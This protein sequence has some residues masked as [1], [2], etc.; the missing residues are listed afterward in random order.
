MSRK[1]PGVR[2]WYAGKTPPDDSVIARVEEADDDAAVL[3]DHSVETNEG[4]FADVV[5]GLYQKMDTLK[6]NP[7]DFRTWTDEDGFET[8]LSCSVRFWSYRAA[9]AGLDPPENGCLQVSHRRYSR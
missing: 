2:A 4:E 8:F 1:H 3:Y 6:R 9:R 7:I 5:K